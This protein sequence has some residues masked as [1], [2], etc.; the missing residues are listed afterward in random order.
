MEALKTKMTFYDG[1]SD[2]IYI[3]KIEPKEDG[4]MCV[5]NYGKYPYANN[6]THKTRI[7]V[8]YHEAKEAYDKVIRQKLAKG[9]VVS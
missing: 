9:Y 6:V 4:W 3:A 5:C 8:G 1:H 7:P 2:K